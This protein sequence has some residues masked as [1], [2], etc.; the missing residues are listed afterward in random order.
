ML[1]EVGL[2]ADDVRNA[3]NALNESDTKENYPQRMTC[4]FQ[5]MPT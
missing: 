2:V 3:V 1:K 4:Q 5:S